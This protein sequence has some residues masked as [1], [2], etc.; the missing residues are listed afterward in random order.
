MTYELTLI[1]RMTENLES[2]K[3]TAKK[4]LQKHGVI[5]ISEEPGIIKK[6]AYNIGDDNEAYYIFML[7]EAPADS[8][9]K[10]NMDFRLN[11]EILRYFFIKKPVEKV[12]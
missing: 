11:N 2:L 7:I 9:E 6:L 8:I 12:A 4:I 1:L 3:E 10:M 5:I